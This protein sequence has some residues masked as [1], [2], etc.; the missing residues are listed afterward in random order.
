M[1]RCIF[2]LCV[3]HAMGEMSAFLPVPGSFV[4]RKLPLHNT[5]SMAK[6]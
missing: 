3:A 6:C 1:T 4:T 5:L 2:L